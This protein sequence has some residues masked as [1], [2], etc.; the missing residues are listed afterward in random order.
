MSAPKSW[1]RLDKRDEGLPMPPAGTPYWRKAFAVIGADLGLAAREPDFAAVLAAYRAQG[2]PYG[3]EEAGRRHD[4]LLELDWRAIDGL[5]ACSVAEFAGLAAWL[6][7]YG[8]AIPTANGWQQDLDLGDGTTATLSDLTWRAARGRRRRQ[9]RGGRDHP[10]A[11]GVARHEGGPAPA[12]APGSRR[13][14]PTAG[15]VPSVV[16]DDE[17]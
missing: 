15:W 4:H 9:R 5:R 14:A 3:G 2:P 12:E 6:A 11:Q 17:G 16:R 7:E 10:P 8:G 13:A 1:R